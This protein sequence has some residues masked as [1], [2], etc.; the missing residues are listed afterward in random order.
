M[1]ISHPPAVLPLPDDIRQ[2]FTQQPTL[3][4]VGNGQL[5]NAPLLALLC[6]RE[7]PGSAILETLDRV[8]E[9]VVSGRVVISGF[10]SPLE[11]QVLRSLLR[12]SGKA[13]KV[14]AR[15]LEKH[16]PSPIEQEAI[17]EGRL[18]L[19]SPF[20]SN[21]HRTTRT[22]ALERNRLVI[23]LAEERIVPYVKEQ[24]PLAKL[25]LKNNEIDTLIYN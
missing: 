11:Q 5:L 1:N 17:A 24:S 4:F 13:V 3:W 12:R 25:L 6:S 20:S 16:R 19:I 8:P 10:H 23:A 9:W 15:T 18:L 14:L 2:R 21:I 7:C 22:T